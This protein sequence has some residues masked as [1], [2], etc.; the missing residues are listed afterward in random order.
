MRTITHEKTGLLD[1]VETDGRAVKAVM[2][3]VRI[4]DAGTDGQAVER[5]KRMITIM[6]TL[7]TKIGVAIANADVVKDHPRMD[8]RAGRQGDLPVGHQADHQMDLQV[9]I[10]AGLQAD[11]QEDLTTRDQTAYI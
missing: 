5:M 4:D 6:T 8:H 10:Q 7:T 1:H 11:L 9:D 3:M 2:T